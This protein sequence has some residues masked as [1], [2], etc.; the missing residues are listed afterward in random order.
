LCVKELGSH[1]LRGIGGDVEL[2][3]ISTAEFQGRCF[4]PLRVHVSGIATSAAGGGTEGDDEDGVSDGETA[5]PAEDGGAELA[6][7]PSQDPNANGSETAGGSSTFIPA[8]QQ[9]KRSRLSARSTGSVTSATGP[10]Q[11]PHVLNHATASAILT[12]LS[13]L[14]MKDRMAMVKA[15][16]SA[17]R[18]TWWHG[19]IAD[20]SVH[21]VQ[22]QQQGG[23]RHSVAATP[24]TGTTPAQPPLHSNRRESKGA[25][26]VTLMNTPQ[27]SARTTINTA[28]TATAPAMTEKRIVQRNIYQLANKVNLVLVQQQ[29]QQK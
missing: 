27:E 11:Q 15:L 8:V 21:Y 10:H 24:S 2:L 9:R 7:D 16:V 26:I 4:P 14:K 28:A 20:A 19:S 5:E 18:L 23:S 3:Q 12:L 22:Q 29:Q 6:Q 13:P 17:W 1:G 25:P